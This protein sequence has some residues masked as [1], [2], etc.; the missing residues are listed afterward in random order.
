VLQSK[1]ITPK[2][3]KLSL[4]FTTE[5]I[6]NFNELQ[7]LNYFAYFSEILRVKAPEDDKEWKREDKVDNLAWLL[8]GEEQLLKTKMKNLL[9]KFMFF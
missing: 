3:V 7:D 4:N 6:R 1:L 2:M 5:F 9:V 8:I